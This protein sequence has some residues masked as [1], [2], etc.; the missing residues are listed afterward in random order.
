MPDMRARQRSPRHVV[1][2]GERVPATVPDPIAIFDSATAEPITTEALNYGQRVTV[3]G[4]GAAPI[5]R[6][7]QA[8]AVLG[9]KSFGLDTPFAPLEEIHFL[10][11]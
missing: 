4:I 11:H 2:K 5:L 1:L 3:I 6:S 10:E 8:F 9:P 7:P